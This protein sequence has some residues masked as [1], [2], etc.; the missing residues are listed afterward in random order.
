MNGKKLKEYRQNNKLSCMDM[1]DKISEKRRQMG[2][3]TSISTSFMRTYSNWEKDNMPGTVSIV[4]L[5][6]LRDIMGCSYEY[7]LED[8]YTFYPD[9]DSIKNEYSIPDDC[10]D[11][12]MDKFIPMCK[13]NPIT[14][15]D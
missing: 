10:F 6:I 12:L 9:N 15:M 7:L 14:E 8:T 5:K 4:N 3:S 13:I 2:L 1:A 11:K